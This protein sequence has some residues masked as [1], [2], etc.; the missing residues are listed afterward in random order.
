MLQ[1]VLVQ[2]GSFVEEKE[3]WRFGSLAATTK[4]IQNMIFILIASHKSA[5]NNYICRK[6]PVA[7]LKRL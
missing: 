2:R 4:V 1:L 3:S 5:N 7:G 6:L